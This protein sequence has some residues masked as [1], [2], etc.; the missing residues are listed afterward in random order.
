MVRVEV[1]L[2]IS[3]ISTELEEDRAKWTATIVTAA[4]VGDPEFFLREQFLQMA[5][6]FRRVITKI[7]N[8]SEVGPATHT[9]KV[10]S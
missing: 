1:V 5:E 10:T 7:G 8:W 4:L 2:Q 3:N 6:G 9:R